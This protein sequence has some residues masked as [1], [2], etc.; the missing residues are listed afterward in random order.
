VCGDLTGPYA[1]TSLFLH[2]DLLSGPPAI[3]D[4][5]RAVILNSRT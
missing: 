2:A 3:I 1:K 5:F 4:F